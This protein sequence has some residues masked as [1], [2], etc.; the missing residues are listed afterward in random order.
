MDNNTY[1]TPDRLSE[2][3]LRC[4]S[5][6]YCKLGNPPSTYS[7]SSTLPTSPL[8]S[9]TLFSYKNHSVNSSQGY[10]GCATVHPGLK[11]DNGI[12]AATVE[13]LNICLDDNDINSAS[14]MLKHFR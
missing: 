9:T 6:I 2:D 5:S 13:V 8:F 7:G 1:K 4:I 10:N 11:E 3:I 12:S 14:I